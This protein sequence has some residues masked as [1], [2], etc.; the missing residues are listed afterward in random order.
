MLH[1]LLIN[2]VS[3]DHIVADYKFSHPQTVAGCNHWCHI[4]ADSD[5]ESPA[6]GIVPILHMHIKVKEH[7]YR[8]SEQCWQLTTVRILS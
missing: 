2:C 5:H 7:A 8:R 6:I 4:V 1:A 3:L